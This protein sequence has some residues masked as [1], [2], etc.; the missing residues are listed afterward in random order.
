[1]EAYSFFAHEKVQFIY[2]VVKELINNEVK[3]KKK[4]LR[5]G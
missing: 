4:L 2:S 1:M 3:T 5:A